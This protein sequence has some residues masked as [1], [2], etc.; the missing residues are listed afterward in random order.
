MRDLLWNL[1]SKHHPK[2][3]ILTKPLLFLRATL[4]PLEFF[5]WKMSK[6]HGYQWK[7]DTWNI[8]GVHYTGEAL[9]ALASAQGE[10]YR[11]T[12]VGECITFERVS[13]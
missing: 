10:T 3:T 13:A 2:G 9:R 11:I 4:Y 1:A 5:Y 6:A 12:R 7:S 8:A